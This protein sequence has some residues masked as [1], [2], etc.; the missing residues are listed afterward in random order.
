M[1]SRQRRPE[2]VD[3]AAVRREREAQLA[4]DEVFDVHASHGFRTARLPCISPVAARA[5]LLLERIARL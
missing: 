5:D 4:L 2:A 1:P 3:D